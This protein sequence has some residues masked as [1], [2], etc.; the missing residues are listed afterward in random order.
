MKA[1][2]G[3]E[4]L[5]TEEKVRLC[6]SASFPSPSSPVLTRASLLLLTLLRLPP[7]PPQLALEFLG[8][9]ENEFVNQGINENR[10]I[11]ESLDLA[12]SLLRTFPREQ[13]NRIPKK[14]LD[15]VRLSFS[16]SFFPPLRYSRS[17]TLDSTTPAR[18]A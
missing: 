12:W 17:S 1:V 3:E 18:R 14:V 6:F 10:T 7:T 5:S 4:A 8:R 11:Y 15:Q 2:V 16:S 13:L 9:F